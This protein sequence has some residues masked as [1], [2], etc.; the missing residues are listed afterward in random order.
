MERVEIKY[1]DWDSN[2][3]GFPS[4]LIDLTELPAIDDD[5]LLEELHTVLMENTRIQFVTIKIN[6]QH[7][8][9]VNM[10]I[11]SG[12]ELIDTPPTFIYSEN[13]NTIPP[14]NDISLQFLQKV[15]SESF[16]EL[17][18]A[19]IFSRYY[20]DRRIGYIKAKKLW[21]QSIKNHCEG[22]ADMLLVAFYKSDPCGLITLDFKDANVVNLFIVGILK[23]WRGKKIASI[24]LRE[25]ITKFSDNN[26]I[27]VET[28]ATNKIAQHVYQ[29]NGFKLHHLTYVI[30]CWKDFK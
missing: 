26:R 6:P 11:K 20:L 2:V 19:M 12:A 25:I 4:G 1:L 7:V 30:H 21:T 13:K 24:M 8:K 5:R 28:Q 22:Y 16:L 17:A 15:N 3:L 27:F 14:A 23:K 29:T 10:I 9:L 18:D